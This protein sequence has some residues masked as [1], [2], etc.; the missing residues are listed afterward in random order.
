MSNGQ[1][2]VSYNWRDENERGIVGQ[3][4]QATTA[5]GLTLVRD[6]EEIGY[7]ESIAAFMNRLGDAPHIVLVLSDSYFKS[8]Y[9]M[10]ELQK[11]KQLADFRQRV[12]PVVLSGFRLDDAAAQVGYRDYWEKEKARVDGEL[13]KGGAAGAVPIATEITRYAEF[14]LHIIDWMSELADMNALTEAIH[15]GTNFAALIERICLQDGAAGRDAASDKFIAGVAGQVRHALANSTALHDALR[16]FAVSAGK[17]NAIDAAMHLCE[18]E[19]EVAVEQYL[20]PATRECLKIIARTNRRDSEVWSA[21]KKIL[22][23]LTLLVVQKEWINETAEHQQLA[24][25]DFRFEM[26]VYTWLGVEVVSARYRQMTPQFATAPGKADAEGEGAMAD[27]ALESGWDDDYAVDALLLDVWK[28]VFPA[29]P[30]SVLTS[31][32]LAILQATLKSYEKKKTKHYYIAIAAEER[33]ALTRPAVYQ[34]FRA[35]LPAATV[36]FFGSNSTREVLRVADE[37]D[38]LVVVRDFLNLPEQMDGS[39]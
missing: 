9:C 8:K 5:A 18:A 33:T 24:N 23:Q 15:V 11:I 14:N 28:R 12:N 29:S 2:F 3:L 4:K 20:M 13:M 36:I 21:A 35:K 31:S 17:S 19:F 38:F 1:V 32:D 27:T 22:A 37:Y 16:K 34:K 7:G 25:A 10:Y 6:S 26:P 30:R 39:P